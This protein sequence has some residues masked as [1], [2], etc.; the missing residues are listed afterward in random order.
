MKPSGSGLLFVG[1][2][3][4]ITNSVSLLVIG[5]FILSIYSWFRLG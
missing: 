3:F 4:L 2:F 1:V 5:L